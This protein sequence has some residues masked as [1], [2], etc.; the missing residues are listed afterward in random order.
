MKRWVL[1]AVT[2]YF[3]W[4]ASAQA[5]HSISGMYDTSREIT[6]E[7]VVTQFQFVNPHPF[8][9]VSVE[10]RNDE[11]QQWRMELDNR[12]ELTEIGVNSATLKPGDRVVVIG[13]PGRSQPQILYIR[14]LDRPADGLRYEQIGASPHIQFPT[15]R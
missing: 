14:R 2:G 11:K 3:L 15:K 1:P 8:V 5:H 9:T 13:S 12:S 6:L 7:G 4:I 10:T